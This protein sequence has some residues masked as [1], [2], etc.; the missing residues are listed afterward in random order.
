[1]KILI[2]GGASGIGFS[3]AKKLSYDNNNDVYIGVHKKNQIETIKKKINDNKIN[4]SVVKLDVRNKKD[5]KII[6]KIK[7]M[8]TATGFSLFK[9]L[10]FIFSPSN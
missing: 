1:M 2:V 8:K 6:N 3:L 10:S 4:I 5:R 7:N 9:C